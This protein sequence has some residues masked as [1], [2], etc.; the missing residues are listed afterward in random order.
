MTKTETVCKAAKL[1]YKYSA[2]RKGSFI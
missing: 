1:T 2:V